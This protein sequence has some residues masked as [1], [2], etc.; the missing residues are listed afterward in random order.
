M[1]RC[2]SFSMAMAATLMLVLA[3][4]CEMGPTEVDRQQPSLSL[5]A[6]TTNIL[7]GE[8]TTVFAQ[9]A[10]LL[11]REVDIQWGTTLGEVE[12]ARSGRVAQF[13]SDAPGT[14]VVTAE[15]RVNG[16]VLRDSVNIN[17]SAIE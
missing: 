15:M 10:N 2:Y 13:R 3:A 4:G 14:A 8:S 16:Q 17:V 5:D 1:R 6:S 12:P 9:T 7:V 11:G